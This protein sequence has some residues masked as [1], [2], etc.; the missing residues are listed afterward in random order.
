MAMAFIL[1]MASMSMPMMVIIV[2]HRLKHLLE[3]LGQ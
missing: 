1:M 3:G 2:M